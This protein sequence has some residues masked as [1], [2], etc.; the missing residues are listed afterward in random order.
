MKL[1][2]YGA[3]WCADFKRVQFWLDQEDIKYEYIDIDKDEEAAQHV[4]DVNPNGFRSI[5]VLEFEDGSVLIEPSLGEVA[6][7]FGN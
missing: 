6:D 2:I 7:K 4:I 5:P 1:K 3:E